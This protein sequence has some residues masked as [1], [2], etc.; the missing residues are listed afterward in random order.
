[1]KPVYKAH[2]W[3]GISIG[4]QAPE[5]VNTFIEIVP[6]DT[7]KYEIDKDTG[8]L[9]IDRPQKYSN[10]VPSLYG[11]VPQTYC[12]R[13]VADLAL[14]N[15]ADK[16]KI[17]D[18]DPLDICVLSSHNIPHGDILLQARPIGGFCLVDNL[19][20]DDKII[21]VLV[22]DH[23]Y[24]EYQDLA[25]MPR[26][27]VERLKHYFLTYKNLPDEPKKCEIAYEYGKK[28]AGQVIRESMED[29]RDLIFKPM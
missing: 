23:I 26:D 21:A 9:K 12:G 24:G 3:H 16:V 4:D 15:G 18:G 28:H 7:I 6:S 13:R 1:M 22:G 2:P 14:K 5:F 25:D 17:G 19:E 8:Y 29:Y 10:I 27:V 11:F 20:A